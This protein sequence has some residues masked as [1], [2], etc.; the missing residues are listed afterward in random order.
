MVDWK[1][2][3]SITEEEIKR[4]LSYRRNFIY[5]LACIAMYL[6]SIN[7]LRELVQEQIF[8]MIVLLQLFTK[9]F[10]YSYAVSLGILV[11]YGLSIDSFASDKQNKALETILTTPLS[12]GSLWL[13]KSLALFILSYPSTIIV[14]IS[15]VLSANLLI[16]SS[17]VYMPETPI[18]ISL[19]A[20]FPFTCLSIIGLIGIGILVSRRVTAVNFITFLSAFLLM[21][22]PS[23]LKLGFM[24]MSA[25]LFASAYAGITAILLIT[26]F[27]CK[28]SY[29]KK[30]KLCL[31]PEICASKACF[32]VERKL[33]MLNLSEAIE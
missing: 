18:W 8:P 1:L 3:F 30:K 19:L 9:M 24:G 32:K 16:A 21:F 33:I 14:F 23:F 2:V 29:Y 22:I 4:L 7:I 10:T 27:I 31:A 5:I 20:I 25:D 15:Y 26:V 11:A 17:F 28:N 13:A 12:L 6:I